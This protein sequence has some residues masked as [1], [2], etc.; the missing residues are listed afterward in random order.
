MMTGVAMPLVAVLE[1]VSLLYVYRSHDFQ[2]DARL[3]TED[4]ACAA[5]ISIQWHIIPLVSLVRLLIKKITFIFVV[6]YILG[7]M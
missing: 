6:M 3:A 5:R 1:L 2:S 4:N 7:Y